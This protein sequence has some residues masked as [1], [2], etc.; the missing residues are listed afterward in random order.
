VVGML[1][2]E[3]WGVSVSVWWG[4]MRVSHHVD[5]VRWVDVAMVL[6]RSLRRMG[7]RMRCFKICYVR[8]DNFTLPFLVKR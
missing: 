1:W 8:R 3:W 7:R 2:F 6:C 4:V 5:G